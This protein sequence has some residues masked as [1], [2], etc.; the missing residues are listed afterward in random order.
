MT[1]KDIVATIKNSFPNVSSVYFV[2]CG[3]SQADLYVAKYFL[4][5]NAKQ[6]CT[7]LITANEFNYDPPK[8]LGPESIVIACSLGGTTPETVAAAKMARESGSPVICLTNDESSPLAQNGDYVIVHGF[9]E[10]YS[11]KMQKLTKALTLAVEILQQYEGYEDYE[12]MLEGTEKIYELIDASIPFVKPLAQKFALECKDEPFIY[13]MGSGPSQMVAYTF[14][15]FILMEMQWINSASFSTGEFFHGPF[16]LVDRNVPYL[17]LMND[18][19][20]R[21]MDSRALE[22]LERF[23]AK[24]TVVDAKDYGLG[25]T[26]S[27]KVKDYFNPILIDG[28]LRVYGEELAKARNHPLTQRRYM[29][30]IHY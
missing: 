14:S 2:G 16:E 7:D 8:N 10:S 23:G 11:A 26:I 15:S 1:I 13:V 9:H 12:L 21:Y 28:I 3:A 20:T 6:L 5:R 18:G 19:N 22:F 24:T 25:S 27:E 29:W 30:K 4:I 17:L